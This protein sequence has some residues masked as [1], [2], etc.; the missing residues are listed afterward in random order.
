[1]LSVTLVLLMCPAGI[2]GL[3]DEA[4]RLIAAEFTA[5][6]TVRLTATTTHSLSAG[7]LAVF[8]SQDYGA[9]VPL[10]SGWTVSGNTL[11]FGTA[12]AEGTVLR[13]EGRNGVTGIVTASNGDGLFPSEI[14]CGDDFVDYTGNVTHAGTVSY[15][16]DAESSYEF[17]FVGSGFC[18]A[19][20]FRESIWKKC[21]L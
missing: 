17:V 16:N 13:I 4:V 5:A 8:A 14:T 7:E 11:T 20:I 6:D 3:A 9:F 21:S 19:C 18:I 10:A 15:L 1:M 2:I 12:L